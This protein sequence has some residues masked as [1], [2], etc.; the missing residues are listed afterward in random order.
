VR[1]AL[2]LLFLLAALPAQAREARI[3]NVRTRPV[4]PVVAPP[5]TALAARAVLD[6]EASAG[7]GGGL[8]AKAERLNCGYDG[9]LDAAGTIILEP[10]EMAGTLY[11]PVA[12]ADS[13]DLVSI[14]LGCFQFVETGGTPLGFPRLL[15]VD[16]YH[17]VVADVF[18]FVVGLDVEIAADPNPLGEFYQVDVQGL[19]IRT[20]SEIM[21]LIGDLDPT[22][23]AWLIPAGDASQRCLEGSNYCSVL[24]VPETSV[25]SDPGLYLYAVGDPQACPSAPNNTLLFDVALEVEVNP[26]TVPARRHGIG[27]WKAG[28]DR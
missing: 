24:L 2:A 20:G 11:P 28:Y 22:P 19:G 10:G 21:V 4:A 12:G 18:E 13:L 1:L 16:V 15:G 3:L 23:T 25:S 7:S 14:G 6:A 17:A 9:S 27:R 5:S 8:S 26:V